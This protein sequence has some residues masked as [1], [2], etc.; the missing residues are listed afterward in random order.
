MRYAYT[1]VVDQEGYGIG[2]ADEGTRGYTPCPQYGR[3]ETYDLAQA[4]A[5]ELNAEA[6]VDAAEAFRLVAETM[7]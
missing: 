7:R 1:A 6:G 3:F 4:R 2:R 5:A